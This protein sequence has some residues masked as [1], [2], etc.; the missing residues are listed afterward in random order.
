MKSQRCI[1]FPNQGGDNRGL[2]GRRA[3][4]EEPGYQRNRRESGTFERRKFG[5]RR[6]RPA[7]VTL[8]RFRVVGTSQELFGSLFEHIVPQHTN[9]AP[10]GTWQIA[11]VCANLRT[12]RLHPPRERHPPS[13]IACV[14][15][16]TLAW[17]R[18][19][20]GIVS[21]VAGRL[22]VLVGF[23]VRGKAIGR[24]VWAPSFERRFKRSCRQ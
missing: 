24:S 14:Y 16:Q 12:A 3:R 2:G 10:A 18:N 22:Q 20:P 21:K 7:L 19:D 23:S 6:H 5:L 9:S 11:Y 17:R 4:L 8:V 1:R 15:R 13:R